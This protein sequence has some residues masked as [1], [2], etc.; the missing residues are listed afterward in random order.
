MSFNTYIRKW[1]SYFVLSSVGLNSNQKT[2]PI[3]QVE[4]VSTIN[5]TEEQMTMSYVNRDQKEI[6]ISKEM[7][8]NIEGKFSL[9][10]LWASPIHPSER[11][12]VF[13]L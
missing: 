8:L 1:N 7:C 12:Y 10:P 6:K 9:E 2:I 5:K 4:S 11:L 3:P 13:E